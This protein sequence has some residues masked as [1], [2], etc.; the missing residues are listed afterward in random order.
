MSFPSHQS[1]ALPDLGPATGLAIL[2]F[3]AHVFG[4]VDCCCVR[5][6]YGAAFGPEAEHA[7]ADLLLLARLVGSEGQRRVALSAPG[8]LHMTRDEVSLACALTAAQAWDDRALAAHLE[9]LLGAP[10]GDALKTLATRIADTFAG[11]GLAFEAPADARGVPEAQTPAFHLA[12]DAG[13]G[14]AARW[15]RA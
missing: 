1:A 2:G 13:A 3:R 6:G 14:A 7:L 8:C 15:P 4:D 5:S 9:S 10:A 12:G 11:H